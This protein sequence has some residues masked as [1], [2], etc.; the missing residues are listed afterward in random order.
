MLID[1]YHRP[2]TYLR[3]SVTDR[4]NLRCQYCMP[5]EGLQWMPPESLMQDHEIEILLRDVFLPLGVTKIRLTGGEPLV[6]KDLP[7]LIARISS[8]PGIQDVSLSTNAI[9]LAPIAERLA[10]AGL[11]RV[12]VSLDSLKPERYAEIT[13]GG[14]LSKVLKGIS[15]ALEVGIAPVKVNVVLI[16]GTNE[17]EALD[18]AAMTLAQ[19]VHVRFIE[20]MQVGDRAFFEE[21]R[22]VPSARIR[23]RIQ[24][25]YALEPAEAQVPGNGPARI[26]RIPGAEGTVGF[27][28]PMSHNFCDTCNR[29]RLT[30]DGQIKACLMRPQEKDLLGMLRAGASPDAMRQLVNASLGNKP[31]HHEWG[32]DEPIFR[33]MSQIGG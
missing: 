30:A 23:E 10:A 9:Y 13:R 7:G 3:L 4:C 16:P 14:D 11:N 29:I 6:R 26:V 1:A 24:E 18:F 31:L 27:I 22:F 25:R 21:R 17:D 5:G 2:I 8:L 15:R 32:A 12:N 28:S 19:P 33:T 20:M